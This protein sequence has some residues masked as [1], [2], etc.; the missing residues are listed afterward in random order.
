MKPTMRSAS[1]KEE[2]FYIFFYSLRD[3]LVNSIIFSSAIRKTLNS[4]KITNTL[5]YLARTDT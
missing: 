2:Q 5:V 3:G 1:K 4:L